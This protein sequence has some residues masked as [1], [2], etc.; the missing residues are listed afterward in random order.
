MNI[1]S[2]DGLLFVNWGVKLGIELFIGAFLDA[3]GH[4]YSTNIQL[5]ENIQEDLFNGK[6]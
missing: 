4:S 6:Y 3:T 5:G 2:V 1:F